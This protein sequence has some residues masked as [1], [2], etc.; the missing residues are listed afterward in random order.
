MDTG[1]SSRF[2]ENRSE[3]APPTMS[4]VTAYDSLLLEP[5]G[6]STL[7][8]SNP[9]RCILQRSRVICH[10]QNNRKSTRCSLIRFYTILA[11]DA[12]GGAVISPTTPSKSTSFTGMLIRLRRLASVR[13]RTILVRLGCGAGTRHQH[14]LLQMSEGMDNGITNFVTTASAKHFSLRRY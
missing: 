11:S 2:S 7:R 3:A 1:V 9:V 8:N 4:S 13:L 6:R 14:F 12:H 10:A 5:A